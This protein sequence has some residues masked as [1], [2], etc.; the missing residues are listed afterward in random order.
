VK[1]FRSQV[2]QADAILF[3][4][5]ENNYGVSAALKNAIDWA[6]RAP[7]V[8]NGKT[9]AIVSSGGGAGGVRSHYQVRQA[10]VYINIFFLNKEVLVRRFEGQHFDAEGNLLNE[11]VKKQL[12][13][14]LVGLR[15][16]TLKLK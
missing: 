6:S 15:N 13:E 10:G 3:A 2:E 8:W 7:N 9:A 5:P 14:L 11:T 12:S 16:L 4:S 1:K